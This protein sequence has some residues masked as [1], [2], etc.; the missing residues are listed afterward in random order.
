MKSIRAKLISVVVSIFLLMS[1]ATVLTGILSSYQSI[2]KN[3]VSD[4]TSMG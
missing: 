2:K 4:M 3:L 1:L